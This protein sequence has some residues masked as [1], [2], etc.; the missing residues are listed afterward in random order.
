M[1]IAEVMTRSAHR[2]CVTSLSCYELLKLLQRE[3]EEEGKG[4]RRRTNT[5]GGQREREKERDAYSEREINK[6][7]MNI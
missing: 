1:E 5:E 2:A 3:R 4:E 6:Q 7:G